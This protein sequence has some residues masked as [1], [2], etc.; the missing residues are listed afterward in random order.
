[1][2]ELTVGRQCDGGNDLIFI[3]ENVM[4]WSEREMKHGFL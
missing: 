2:V 3:K 4:E 1:M